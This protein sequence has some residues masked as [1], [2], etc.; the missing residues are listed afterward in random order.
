V[1]KGGNLLLN[2]GPTADG[3]M[4][5]ENLSRMADM[6]RW[7]EVNGEAIYGT[8]PWK[9][10]GEN[11]DESAYKTQAELKTE[12]KDE[13]FDGTPKDVVQDIRFTIKGKNLYVIAR[14]WRQKEV[15][16]KSLVENEFRIKSVSMLGYKGRIDWTQSKLGTTVVI[17]AKAVM[18]IPI[19]VFKFTLKTQTILQQAN[20]SK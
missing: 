16:I 3:I 15:L 12:K 8:K 13:V 14:S 7:L 6:G 19:Y 5:T 17:P 10:F 2:T 11:A 9:V 4:P 18:N 1:S 20:Q